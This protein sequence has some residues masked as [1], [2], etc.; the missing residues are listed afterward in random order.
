L[1]YFDSASTSLHKPDIVIQT[2]AKAMTELG[3]SGRG[4]HAPAMS[5]TRTIY[6]ARE[7]LATFFGTQA[8]QVAFTHNATIALNIAIFSSLTTNDHAI[9]TVLEHNSVLRP[10][11]HL[12]SHGLSLDFVGLATDGDIDYD[13][14]EKLLKKNTKCIVITH[15]SNVTGQLI[16]LERVAQICKKKG[17]VLIV[18]AAQS[19]G[20]FEV[21]VKKL[22]DAIV[23]FTGHKGLLGPQG[24][25]GLVKNGYSPI[26]PTFFGGTGSDSFSHYNSGIFPESFEPGTA[27]A[28]GVAGLAAGVEYINQIGMKKMTSNSLR[29][30]MFFEDEIRRIKN[31]EIYGNPQLPKA[32]IV[33]INIGDLD[34]AEV[35]AMLS[36][37][38][39][40]VRGGF[41]CAPLIHHALGTQKQGAAR[42]SFSSNNTMEQVKIAIEVVNKIAREHVGS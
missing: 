3:N 16:D 27:N 8:N 7:R 1:I 31:V 20:L 35:G 25:G 26:T 17:L 23:C 18:D 9:T 28:H 19:A 39:I 42:F 12:Q 13:A 37:Y 6:N 21:D 34:S 24:T 33:S 5:A 29:L 40:Y 2:V 38:E 11:Y 30:A 4:G 36:E 32:P 10:L 41:H 22:G 14:L 15:C